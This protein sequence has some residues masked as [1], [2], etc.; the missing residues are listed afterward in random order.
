M[1]TDNFHLLFSRSGYCML[2]IS[3]RPYHVLRWERE[4]ISLPIKN[5]RIIANLSLKKLT[6]LGSKVRDV[7]GL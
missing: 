6:Q 5:M 7:E 2:C 4:K 1:L 3:D